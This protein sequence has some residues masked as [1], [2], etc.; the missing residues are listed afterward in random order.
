MLDSRRLR[1]LGIASVGE[2]VA[3]DDSARLIG[4]ERMHI[5]SNVRIDAFCVLSAGNGGIYIGDHV[6]IAAFVFMAGAGRIQLDDFVGLSG[7]V[8]VYSSNDDYTGGALTGPTIPPEFR[9]VTSAPVSFGRHAIVGAGSVVL[10]GAHIGIGA[11]IGA[12]SLARGDVPEFTVFAGVPSRQIGTRSRDL[13]EHEA[14]L[15]EQQR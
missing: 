13:I 12:L 1:E 4:L 3:V 11:S 6:H 8:S 5:G 10:P 2:N 9:N 15:R 14:R 7:R